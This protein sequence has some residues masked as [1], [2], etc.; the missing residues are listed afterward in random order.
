MARLVA[1]AT[2]GKVLFCIVPA[3]LHC[4]FGDLLLISKQQKKA[5]RQQRKAFA[6][7]RQPSALRA[8]EQNLTHTSCNLIIFTVPYMAVN[9][10]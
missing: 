1:T 4:F 8:G 2:A 3:E 9:L 6:N 5:I 7:K 10:Y